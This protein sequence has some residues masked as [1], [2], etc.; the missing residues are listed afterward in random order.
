MYIN[1]FSVIVRTWYLNWIHTLNGI[2]FFLKIFV[3]K[4]NRRHTDLHLTKRWVCALKRVIKGSLRRQWRYRCPSPHTSQWWYWKELYGGVDTAEPTVFPTV[5]NTYKLEHIILHQK[6][7]NSDVDSNPLNFVVLHLY[8][9][10]VCWYLA[11]APVFG[12]PDE[13]RD[14]LGH[15]ALGA[16][17]RICNQTLHMRL[18]QRQEGI[19]KVPKKTLCNTRQCLWCNQFLL[20]FG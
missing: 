20:I 6:V 19:V 8:V 18:Q 11:V 9:M 12:A 3:K 5:T 17:M 1:R 10:N 15:T 7:C 16:L 14:D 13:S 4:L 2:C